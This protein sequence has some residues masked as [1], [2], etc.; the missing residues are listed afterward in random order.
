M[1]IYWQAKSKVDLINN[2][3]KKLKKGRRFL[4]KWLILVRNNNNNNYYLG[5][6]TRLR[7]RSINWIFVNPNFVNAFGKSIVK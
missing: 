5:K 4:I 6:E 3:A 1:V 7:L 2:F